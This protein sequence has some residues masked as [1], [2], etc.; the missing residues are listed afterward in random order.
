MGEHKI[1]VPLIGITHCEVGQGRAG[2]PEGRRRLCLPDAMGRDD[3]D[4]AIRC[5]ERRAEY[6]KA[7]QGRLPDYKVVPYQTAEATCAVY[8]WKDALS[9]RSR[10]TRRRC[11]RR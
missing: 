8:V 4:A 1:E 5:S 6:N 9:A 7:M 11:V 3:E 2:L 10:S